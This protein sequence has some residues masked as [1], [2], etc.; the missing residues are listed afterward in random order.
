MSD[1]HDYAI[2]PS[3]D[4]DEARAFL[5]RHGWVVIK[6]VLTEASAGHIARHL[7]HWMPAEGWR[8]ASKPNFQGE[9]HPLHLDETPDNAHWRVAARARSGRA[10]AEGAF[11]YRLRRT[12]EHKDECDCQWCRFTTFMRE[13]M[14][15]G[16]FRP[17]CGDVA[18]YKTLFASLYTGGDF[19][20]PHTDETNGHFAFAYSLTR[21]WRA[22]YGGLLQ[23]T[24]GQGQEVLHSIVPGW[25]TMT[26]FYVNRSSEHMVSYVAPEVKLPRLAVSG[27]LEPPEAGADDDAG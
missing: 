15:P 9:D 2:N 13:G 12:T 22:Q 5:H 25:N 1:A 11:G 24:S 7:L 23:F 10:L 3:L 6:D 18:G 8:H 21:G 4:L 20:C 27:W 14:L 17:L 26:V 16:L 19:L